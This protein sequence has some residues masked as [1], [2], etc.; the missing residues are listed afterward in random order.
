M[1]YLPNEDELNTAI[2]LIADFLK[3]PSIIELRAKQTAEAAVGAPDTTKTK[4]A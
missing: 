4:N 2:K 3:H 1:T